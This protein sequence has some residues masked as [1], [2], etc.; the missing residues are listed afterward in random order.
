MC[1][2]LLRD[3]L[4]NKLFGFF[5]LGKCL[6]DNQFIYLFEG[7]LTLFYNDQFTFNISTTKLDL[8]CNYMPCYI[9]RRN[10]IIGAPI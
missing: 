2:R 10:I 4:I 1:R 8:K 3:K 6:K 5:I 9:P 7:R